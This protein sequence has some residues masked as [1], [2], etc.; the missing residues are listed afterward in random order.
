MMLSSARVLPPIVLLAILAAC[1]DDDA[2]ARDAG[3]PDARVPRDAQIDAP[4]EMLDAGTDGGPLDAGPPG[5]LTAELESDETVT[6]L[7]DTLGT[8]RVTIEDRDACLRTYYLSSTAVRRDNSPA[9]PPIPSPRTITEREASPSVRTG[10]DLFDALHALAI[11][12]AR[13]NAVDS[14]R[15]YAFDDGASVP[16][17]AEGCFETGRIWNYVWTRDTAY[18]V[19][20]GLAAIDPLRARNSLLF[21]VSDRRAGGRTEIVQDTGTGGSWPISTDR[22]AWALGAEELLRW[23]TPGDHDA[24]AETTLRALR[25]T[26][27]R[28]RGTIFDPED[29]LYRGEQSFLDWREQTYPAWVNA[30][31]APALAHIGMSK[32]LSTNVLH[33]RAIE[34]AAALAEDAGDTTSASRWRGWASDLRAAIHARFWLADEGMFSTYVTTELDPSPVRRFDLLG[35]SLAILGDVATSDEADRILSSYPHLGPGAAPVVHPQQQLTRIYHNRAEWPFVTAYWLRAARHADHD[36]AGDRAVRSLMRAAALNLSNMENLEIATGSPF[37]SEG[38]TSGPVVNSQRQLW[39]VAGY[40]AMVHHVIFGLEASDEGL[41]VRPWITRAMRETLFDSARTLV[42]RNV[43]W[44]GHVLDVVVRL[45]E[46]RTVGNYA[47]ARVLLDG[48]AIGERAITEDELG[49]RARIEV[50]LR[51][52]ASG[53]G[54]EITTLDDPSDWRAIFGPRTPTITGLAREGDRVRVQYALGGDDTSTLRVAIYRDGVRVADELAGTSTSYLDEAT[55]GA[56]TTHCWAVEACFSSSGTCSQ[57]SPPSCDWGLGNERVRIFDASTFTVTGGSP[58]TQYGRFHHQG[59]GDDGHRIEVS[60][61]TPTATGEYFLQTLYGNGGPIDTGITAAVK[62]IVVE[63]A[64]T[65]AMV[66]EGV[67]VMPHMGAWDRWGESTLARVRLEAGR[68]YRFVISA[69]DDTVN[70]SAFQHFATYTANVGG[71]EGPFARVNIAELRV[72]RVGP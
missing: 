26:I 56:T 72:L 41:R 50:E 54:H 43:V 65:G 67:L 40:L 58:I 70:M 28:D 7:T 11:D 3:A 61:F 51:A 53:G 16:C 9:A 17:G 2:P 4:I 30:P 22:V 31:G 47:I 12:E 45:P 55:D 35:E 69:D 14:I 57:H 68:T 36:A 46:E 60:G 6:S 44:R 38:V 5:C 63:D 42:L 21:K 39:S 71:R 52:A 62:R 20:L 15:D 32:T 66:A 59:W 18:S 49:E 23:I 1:G 24:F 34:L 8:A 10:N 25:G 33:L 27:E 37:V 13:E 19:D 64:T 48:A 29:G